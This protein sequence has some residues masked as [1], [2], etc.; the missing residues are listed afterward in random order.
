MND[1]IAKYWHVIPEKDQKYLKV[2]WKMSIIR[3]PDYYKD[4]VINVELP[5]TKAEKE[6]KGIV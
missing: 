4:T 5:L 3:S 6:A 2:L 1:F